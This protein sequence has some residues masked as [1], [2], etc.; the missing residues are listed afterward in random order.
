LAPEGPPYRYRADVLV[1]LRA[2]GVSPTPLTRPALVREFVRDL[3]RFEIRA[4]R[5]AMLRGAFPK[6]EY[7]T[8]V[9]RLRDRY[10]VLALLPRQFIE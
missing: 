7:A 5:A 6:A 4:L 3:Y 10:P 8:R 1:Q 9:G 2:H